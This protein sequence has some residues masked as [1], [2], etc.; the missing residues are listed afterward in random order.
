MLVVLIIVHFNSGQEKLS[1]LCLALLV[2]QQTS[3]NGQTLPTLFGTGS[4]LNSSRVRCAVV[5]DCKIA[6]LRHLQSF[7]I[8]LHRSTLTG[9][10]S[11]RLGIKCFLNWRL[12][13]ELCN[14]DS[15]PGARVHTSLWGEW[16]MVLL[17]EK[18]TYTHSYIHSHWRFR[19]L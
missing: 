16:Q 6:P 3:E 14:A 12:S 7:I 19:H 8:P 9:A 18:Q 13:G 11:V 2:W 10:R 1:D 4:S 17:N 5:W 15:Q